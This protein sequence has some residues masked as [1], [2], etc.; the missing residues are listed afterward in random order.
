MRGSPRRPTNATTRR[1]G[2]DAAS[3]HPSKSKPL[4]MI[5]GSGRH[6]G[7][8][9]SN[10]ARDTQ[11]AAPN[12]P[13]EPRNPFRATVSAHAGVP[14]WWKV[15]TVGQRPSAARRACHPTDGAVGSW[16]CTRSGSTH[17]NQRR[18]AF[19]VRGPHT[20]GA[21]EPFQRTL[22]PPEICCPTLVLSTPVLSTLGAST[23]ASCPAARRAAARPSTWFC[24]P[25]GRARS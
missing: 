17:R 10:A 22:T 24:T 4:P 14:A 12:R 3:A 13:S 20:T 9:A 16:T 25:P 7:A 2:S 23:R 18:T 6:N 11:I 8:A 1:F 21:T 15:A 19:A 5:V